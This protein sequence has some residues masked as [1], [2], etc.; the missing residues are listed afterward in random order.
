MDAF[1][2]LILM[3]NWLLGKNAID[4]RARPYKISREDWFEPTENIK[5]NFAK[6]INCKNHEKIA[7]I[8]PV[9]YE[10]VSVA[11]NIILNSKDEILV[12]DKQY[13]SN[14]YSWVNIFKEFGAEIVV[15]SKIVTLFNVLV[16]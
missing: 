15:Y 6:L 3:Y 8:P 4:L 9:L 13:P 12:I 16:T 7:V 5:R 14:Y 1:E 11:K 10:V 2:W